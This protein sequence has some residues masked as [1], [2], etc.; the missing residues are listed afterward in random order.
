MIS[1]TVHRNHT[2]KYNRDQWNMLE[3]FLDDYLIENFDWRKYM[4]W[5]KHFINTQ[6]NYL[7]MS[8][9]YQIETLIP[10]SYVQKIDTKIDDLTPL[11]QM[12][13]EVKNK[14]SNILSL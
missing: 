1:D 4:N 10:I 6:R 5:E 13:M 9:G 14:L 2:G 3:N 11:S 8:I 12:I 7:T